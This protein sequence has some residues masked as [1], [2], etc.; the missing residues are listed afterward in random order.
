M[1]GMVIWKW[2]CAMMSKPAV[3]TRS[4]LLSA[5]T[6]KSHINA[7]SAGTYTNHGDRPM[8][9]YAG[10]HPYFATTPPG[11]GKNHV[12][13]NFHP[14]RRFRYNQRLTDLV[15]EQP[16]LHL[17]SPVTNPEIHEQLMKLGEDKECHLIYPDQDVIMMAAEGVEDPDLFPYVQIYSPADQPFVCVEPWMSYPNALNSIEGVRWLAPGQSEHG[18]LRLWLE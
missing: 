8:P 14:E 5:C 10:F 16:L 3:F 18:V 6:M 4:T 13:L 12:I 11:Q 1:Q 17:P 2:N 15:G 9:Y 7:Y